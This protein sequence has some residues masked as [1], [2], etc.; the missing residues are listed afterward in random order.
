MDERMER[1]LKTAVNAAYNE[2]LLT[3]DEYFDAIGYINNN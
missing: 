3:D 2:H 1:I